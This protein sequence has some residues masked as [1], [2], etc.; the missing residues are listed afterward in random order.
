MHGLVQRWQRFDCHLYSAERVITLLCTIVMTTLVFLAVV[1]RHLASPDSVWQSLAQRWAPNHTDTVAT[2]A[3]FASLLLWWGICM[4][5]LRTRCSQYSVARLLGTSAG[6][7]GV[8][9]GAAVGMTHALPSGIVFAQRLSLCLLLW[10]IMLGASMA[11]HKRQHLLL[12][13][14]QKLVAAGD[15]RAHVTL[16]L[17]ITS[18]FTIFLV[19]E[20]GGYVLGNVHTWL[21]GPEGSGGFESIPIPTWCISAAIPVGFGLVTLRFLAQALLVW[22]REMT[23]W[24]EETVGGSVSAASEEHD[25]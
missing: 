21:D 10:V 4:L 22:L 12:R 2:V 14:A 3:P 1:W 19:Y 17:L 16:G 24:P 15:A 5:G 25:S 6:I 8:T 7:A 20:G 13:A 18:A 23:P 9:A 11:A